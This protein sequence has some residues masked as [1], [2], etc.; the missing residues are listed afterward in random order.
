MHKPPPHPTT[1]SNTDASTHTHACTHT[2]KQHT[3]MHI[4]MYHTH[5]HPHTDT[6]AHTHLNALLDPEMMAHVLP[7]LRAADVHQAVK[8]T[9]AHALVEHLSHK[10]LQLKFSGGRNEVIQRAVQMSH[11]HRAQQDSIKGL[12][13]FCR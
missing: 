7:V 3:H 12:S 1:H 11:K 8:H 9:V 5:V 6:H 4:H 13:G 2:H 10:T